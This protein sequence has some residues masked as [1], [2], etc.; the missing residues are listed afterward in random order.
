MYVIVKASS[1][2][3]EIPGFEYAPESSVGLFFPLYNG[4]NTNS[5]ILGY[6]DYN[7]ADNAGT[8]ISTVLD[9]P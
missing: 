1:L 4:G 8:M 3:S 2:E 6:C 7:R 5:Y 9:V